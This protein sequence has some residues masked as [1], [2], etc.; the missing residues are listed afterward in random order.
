VIELRATLIVKLGGSAITRKDR[1]FSPRDNVLEIVAPQLR[2]LVEVDKE[3]VIVIHGGGS[4]GHPVASA[5]SIDKGYTNKGQLLGFSKVK[6]AML[7]LHLKILE[8]LLEYGV[9]VAPFS[10]SNFVLTR[11]GVPVNFVVKP[12]KET[13]ELGLIPLLHGD[14]VIDV[15]WGFYIISGDQLAFEL[16]NRL[17]VKKVIF[18]TDVKGIYTEDPKV[19]ERAKLIRVIR[20]TDKICVKTS[21][22]E[23]VDVTGGIL[24]KLSYAIALAKMGIPVVIGDITESE[25]LLR[26]VRGNEK[27]CTLILP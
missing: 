8:A 16:A 19:S 18:G 5:Y 26:L 10:P 11:K 20:V 27:E 23:V 14:V 4:F 22:E 1:V 21:G 2:E 24:R 3:S 15:E 17:P 13:L 12:V 6:R 25:G 7:V 9:P